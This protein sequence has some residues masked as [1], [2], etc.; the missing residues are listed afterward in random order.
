MNKNS[1]LDLI[2]E[3][4]KKNPNRDISHPEVV[5]WVVKEWEKRT[6]KVLETPIEELENCMKKVICKKSLKE[7]I[8]TTPILRF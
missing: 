3:F 6:G 8:D 7:F 1:Q 4:F 2:M 5:D